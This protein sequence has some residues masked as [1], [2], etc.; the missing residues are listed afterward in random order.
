[1]SQ[2]SKQKWALIIAF[3]V[4]GSVAFSIAAFALNSNLVTHEENSPATEYARQ[5]GLDEGIVEKIKILDEIKAEINAD[6][7][8]SEN[9]RMFID[10]VSGFNQ[11]LQNSVVDGFL[12]DGFVTSDDAL[13][14]EFLKAMPYVQQVNSIVNGSFTDT[15]WDKDRMNNRF[16]QIVGMP[17]DV[18]NGRYALVVNSHPN[19]TSGDVLA[20]FYIKE[21]G[22]DPDNVIKLV[23]NNA[24]K[25]KFIQATAELSHRVGKNDFVFISYD[26]HDKEGSFCFSDYIMSHE[27]IDKAIDAIPAGKMVI[28]TSSCAGDAPLAVLSAGHSQRVVADIPHCWIYG[29]SDAYPKLDHAPAAKVYDLDG[30]GYISFDEI[31][32]TTVKY[33]TMARSDLLKMSDISNIASDLYFSDLE[34]QD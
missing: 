9:E 11:T 32:K 1:M 7:N 8:L 21:H 22:F 25:D 14:I 19:Q 15:D 34:V 17:W 20:D 33:Q 29:S 3:I 24:T 5:V 12:S 23:G 10:F 4:V 13:Q 6:G 31:F 2:V 27:D 30:N 26:G 18:Y 16:E 28:T